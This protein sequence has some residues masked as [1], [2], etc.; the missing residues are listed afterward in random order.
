M[1]LE[2]LEVVLLC[3]SP[4]GGTGSRGAGDFCKGWAVTEYRCGE[5]SNNRWKK[6]QCGHFGSGA[7]YLMQVAQAPRELWDVQ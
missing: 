2:T 6:K 1:G 4:P 3:G 7:V 5:G